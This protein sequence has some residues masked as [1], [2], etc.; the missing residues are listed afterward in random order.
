MYERYPWNDYYNDTN[1]RTNLPFMNQR[2]SLVVPAISALFFAI[3]TIQVVVLAVLIVWRRNHE[4]VKTRSVWLL[5]MTLIAESFVIMSL[6][7]KY[8]IGR[9]R[10][11]CFLFAVTFSFCPPF[12]FIPGILRIWR[13]IVAN[14]L[15]SLGSLWN[16]IY[17]TNVSLEAQSMKDSVS[18]TMAL[19][20]FWLSNKFIVLAFV[21][22]SFVP[23]L[24]W[25]IISTVSGDNGW[26]QFLKFNSSC[27]MGTVPSYIIVTQIL[28]YLAIQF[29]LIIFTCIR[30]LHIQHQKSIT[31][32]VIASMIIWILFLTIFIVIATL[33]WFF[34]VGAERYWPYAYFMILPCFFDIIINIWIPLIYSFNNQ[35]VTIPAAE[36]KKLELLEKTNE[37]QRVKRKLINSTYYNVQLASEE[38]LDKFV[39]DL[40]DTHQFIEKYLNTSFTKTVAVY[41]KDAHLFRIL[42]SRLVQE[43]MEQK[44]FVQP[45]QRIG[46]VEDDNDEDDDDDTI[47]DCDNE[48]CDSDEAMTVQMIQELTP[49]MKDVDHKVKIKLAIT[50][51]DNAFSRGN[52]ISL[53]KLISPFVSFMDYFPEVGMFH[54]ALLVGPWLLEYNNSGLCIPRKCLS[55]KAILTVDITTVETTGNI[56]ELVENIAKFIIRVNGNVEYV[57]SGG[58]CVQTMNCQDFVDALLSHLKFEARI[59]KESPIGRFIHKLRTKGSSNLSFHPSEHFIQRFK[60]ENS[61]VTFTTHT[62]IDQFV[63]KLMK[64]DYNFKNNYSAEYKLLKAFDRAMWMKYNKVQKKMQ[65]L[66][67]CEDEWRLAMEEHTD[68]ILKQNAYIALNKVKQEYTNWH[69]FLTCYHPHEIEEC[70]QCPFG[71]PDDTSSY[72]WK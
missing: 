20:K 15:Q 45:Q 28:I 7:A 8:M 42:Q 53:R 38:V 29:V 16:V 39:M 4:P 24:F 63:E 71:D 18:R 64:L 9:N 68:P 27:G 59:D 12:A 67:T 52:K 25:I 13:V 48:D 66:L 14:E 62:E 6:S 44:Q 36:C 21:V 11:P 51:V 65:S 5:L 26:R 69:Q 35:Q 47:D 55:D 54:S 72:A 61:K 1:P 23:V 34:Y 17:T 30:T 60:L 3:G 50:E 58:D 19:W 70:S 43:K 22:T 57:A 40:V 41:Q 56:L 2:D 49:K 31:Y 10:Y 32:E 46:G 37:F 33:F